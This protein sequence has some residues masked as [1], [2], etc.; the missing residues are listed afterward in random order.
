MQRRAQNNID[1]AAATAAVAAAAAAA[2][3][4]VAVAV[5][6]LG[7]VER[8]NCAET[9]M[10]QRRPENRRKLAFLSLGVQRAPRRSSVPGEVGSFRFAAGA[11][12]SLFWGVSLFLRPQ[13]L[14]PQ[15]T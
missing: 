5:A 6:Y 8:W 3:V 2:A 1:A 15:Q 12:T 9:N 4:A 14:E 10:L 7:T 13:F 11:Q